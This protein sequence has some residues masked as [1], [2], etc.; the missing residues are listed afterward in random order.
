VLYNDTDSAWTTGPCLAVSGD[1]PLSEDLL[2]YTP[3]A[4]RCEIPM[5]ASVNIA[6]EKNETESQRA[7]K[8]SNP[9]TDKFYDLVT[10]EGELKLKNF[11]KREV[12]IAITNHVPGKPISASDGGVL[13]TDSTKLQL[14]EREGNIRWDVKLKP[15]DS[16]TIQYKYERYVPS[17]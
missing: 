6:H 9:S 1:Q 4:G 12:E 2:K 10:L 16:K 5:T 13:A 15:G 7:T 8:A 14:L 11:E 17:G 3:K